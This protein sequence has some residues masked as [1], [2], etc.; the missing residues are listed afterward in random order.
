MVIVRANA[1]AKLPR[2]RF[3]A[4]E[5]SVTAHEEVATNEYNAT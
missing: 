2:H 3:D 5:I 4:R 1:V